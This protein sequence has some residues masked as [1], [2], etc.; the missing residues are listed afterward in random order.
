MIKD[1]KFPLLAIWA[2][3]FE[4]ESYKQTNKQTNTKQ[5]KAKTKKQNN[6]KK[7]SFGLWSL[8]R[9]RDELYNCTLADYLLFV[10]GNC[11]LES[12]LYL[13]NSF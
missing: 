12:T 6:N 8:I 5:N 9:R 10:T 4:V 1:S 7:K 13:L 3:G 2:I 11:E